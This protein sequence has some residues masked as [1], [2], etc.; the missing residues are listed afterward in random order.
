MIYVCQTLNKMSSKEEDIRKL[1]LE[2]INKRRNR[3]I[4]NN[5]N[6]SITEIVEKITYKYGL[7]KHTFKFIEYCKTTKNSYQI[8]YSERETL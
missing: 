8:T 2:Y 6:S 5:P 1:A 7:A 3:I 4:E